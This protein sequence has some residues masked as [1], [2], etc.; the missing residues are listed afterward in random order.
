MLRKVIEQIA[1]RESGVDIG[2]GDEMA[3]A[4]AIV[5][6]RTAERGGVDVFAGDVAHDA[7]AGQEHARARAS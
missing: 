3:D 5:D 6:A 1:G 7:G 2:L 4:V